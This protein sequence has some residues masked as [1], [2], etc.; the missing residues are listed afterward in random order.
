M[1]TYITENISQ[2]IKIHNVIRTTRRKNLKIEID[3]NAKIT[4]RVP[5]YATNADIV[6]FLENNYE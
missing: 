6:N 4:L 1:Q 5:V 3:N 2:T